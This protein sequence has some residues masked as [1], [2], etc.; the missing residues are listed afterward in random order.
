MKKILIYSSIGDRFEFYKQWSTLRSENVQCAYNYYG[1]NGV[2]R[3]QIS[4]AA[5]YFSQIKG[6]KFNLFSKLN[7]DLSAYD[8]YVLLDDDLN[9]TPSDIMYMID[10]MELTGFGI[11]SP[12][13]SPKGRISHFPDPIMRT[14]PDGTVR[15]VEFVEM[16]AVIFNREEMQKFLEAYTPVADRM[17]GWGCDHIIYSVC[18]KP[19]LIFDNVSVVNPTNQQKGI[20][21][22]EIETYLAGRN[23][24]QLW[25]AV[26][27]DP[28]NNFIEWDGIIK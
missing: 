4:H 17:V 3:N 16:T 20:K 6:T 10:F 19:F 28:S 13:H 12:S 25:K 15:E 26:L 14:I 18:K 2:I 11:A 22:R 5:D 27:N 8:Y 24:Q 9:L 7:I 21:E 23:G 1:H